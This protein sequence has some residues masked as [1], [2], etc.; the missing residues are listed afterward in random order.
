MKRRS[1]AERRIQYL[2]AAIDL[3]VADD[4]AA[5]DNAALALSH[6]KIDDVALRAGVSKGALYHVWPSQ[7]AYWADLL[8]AMFDDTTLNGPAFFYWI[9]KHVAGRDGDSVTFGDFARFAYASRLEN[10]SLFVRASLQAYHP[11]MRMTQQWEHEVQQ[12]DEFYGPTMAV[13]LGRAGRRFKDDVDSLEMMAALEAVITGLTLRHYFAPDSQYQFRSSS[14]T[15]VGLFTLAMESMFL[16]NS[17]P[18]DGGDAP[19]PEFGE[20]LESPLDR[21]T[22][23]ALLEHRRQAYSLDAAIKDPDDRAEFYIQ[24]GLEILNDLSPQRA[25]SVGVDAFANIRIADIANHVGV[26]KA[27][28]YHIWNSQE[29]FRL[30][31]LE[32][33]LTT[34]TSETLKVLSWAMDT[35]RAETSDAEDFLQR[36]CDMSFDYLKDDARFFA[37][38]SF[39]LYTGNEDVARLLRDAN[40]EINMLFVSALVEYISAKGWRLRDDVP[41]DILVTYSESAVQGL[42]LMYRI[43]PDT[44]DGHRKPKGRK[45]AAALPPSRLAEVMAAIC[46]R[47]TVPVE[48]AEEASPQAR[49]AGKSATEDATT[50]NASV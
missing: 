43:S 44:I 23:T 9:D 6:V 11:S 30:D 26:S 25:A 1:R 35:V 18:I 27:S 49:G 16:Y 2:E 39:A 5:G 4:A 45:R 10:P 15:M 34:W 32:Y 12:L 14:G 41:E 28:V 42:C 48:T 17:E 24:S 20:L 3:I 31:V 7:E 13:V 29:A 19:L 46:E 47:V 8:K 40:R 50:E 33:L 22:V 38:F 36:I 21:P 37:R